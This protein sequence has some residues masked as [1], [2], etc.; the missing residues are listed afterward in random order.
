[1]LTAIRLLNPSSTILDMALATPYINA[2]E[3][4]VLEAYEETFL[5]ET[6]SPEGVSSPVDLSDRPLSGLGP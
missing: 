2:L 4:V 3:N 1:M 6:M 5:G